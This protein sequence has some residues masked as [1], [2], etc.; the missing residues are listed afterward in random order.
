MLIFTYFL[1]QSLR[2]Y[3]IMYTIIIV[4]DMILVHMTSEWSIVWSNISNEY[5]WNY[6]IVNSF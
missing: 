1:N 2:I 4:Y 5:W 6:D 3:Q